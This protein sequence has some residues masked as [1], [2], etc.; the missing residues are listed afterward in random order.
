MAAYSPPPRV[1]RDEPP[2]LRRP[3]TGVDFRQALPEDVLRPRQLGFGV[4]CF[5][6]LPPLVLQDHNEPG[7]RL[8]FDDPNIFQQRTQND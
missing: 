3:V 7:L 5:E 4:S 6:I 1:R 8:D 2:P